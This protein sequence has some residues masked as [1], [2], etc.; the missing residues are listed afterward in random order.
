VFPDRQLIEARSVD[1]V[2]FYIGYNKLAICTG[3]QV[4]VIAVYGC[5]EACWMHR[6]QGKQHL[7]VL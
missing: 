2:K 7:V 6:R 4:R 5:F 3:S 1:G